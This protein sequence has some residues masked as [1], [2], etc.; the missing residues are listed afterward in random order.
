[1][2][3]KRARQTKFFRTIDWLAFRPALLTSFL[4][5]AGTVLGEGALPGD[6]TA[7]VIGVDHAFDGGS[8]LVELDVNG[9]PYYLLIVSPESPISRR[10]KAGSMPVFWSRDKRFRDQADAVFTADD[11]KRLVGALAR[12]KKGKLNENIAAVLLG[13]RAD[14]KIRVWG[15]DAVESLLNGS[16]LLLFSEHSDAD[17]EDNPFD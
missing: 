10:I 2:I 7:Q 16:W 14:M 13:V 1:M 17:V 15:S 4:L 5:F 12:S 3:A 8:L 11:L 6:A 9:E